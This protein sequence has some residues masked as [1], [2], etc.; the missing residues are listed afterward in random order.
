[1]EKIILGPGMGEL[2]DG[3]DPA[4]SIGVAT[5]R[6]SGIDVSLSGLIYPDGNTIE[7]AKSIFEIIEEVIADD[8]NGD[9][10]D[11]TLLRLYIRDDVFT[12][13]LRQDLHELRHDL[14]EYPDFPAATMVG[15]SQLVHED[16]TIEIEVEALIPEEE[17]DK[18]IIT[19]ED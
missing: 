3:T 15:V 12:T 13:E 16:A 18:T 9:F 5:E 10:A 7:Q 4:M 1:M 14:F 2:E 8:L 6:A 19:P 17:W 11:I